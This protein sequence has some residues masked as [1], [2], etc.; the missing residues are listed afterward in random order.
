MSRPNEMVAEVART[1]DEYAKRLKEIQGQGHRVTMVQYDQGAWVITYI[2]SP[3]T[4]LE[5]VLPQH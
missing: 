1:A 4:K 2:T 3:S 5:A